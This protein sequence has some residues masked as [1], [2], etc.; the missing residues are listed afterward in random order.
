MTISEDAQRQSAD[1]AG[2]GG[3]DIKELLGILRRRKKVI[4]STVLL[5]TSLAVLAGLQLTPKYTAT[6]MVMI[7]PRK[8]T[9]VDVEAVIQG[10][11]TDASTVESQIRLISSRF[12][13]ERLATD[14]G[15]FDDP[16]FNAALR[17]PDR[18]VQLQVAGPLEVIVSWLPDSWLVATGLA[19][20]PIE[21]A[22]VDLPYLQHESTIEA[23][24]KGLKVA[25]E[26]RSYV[27][28]IA[29]TSENAKKAANV[30]NAAANRYVDMLREEKVGKTELATEWLAQRLDELRR[31]VEVAEGAAEEYRAKNNINDVNG[32][33]LNEQRLFDVNQRLSALR[34]DYAAA[35]AKV[36]QIRAMRISGFD[37]TEAVPEVLA[38]AT[39]INL[40]ER[41]T[42]LL[43]EESDMRSTYGAKHPRI[44]SI[45]QEKS[46]LQRKIQAE[47]SRILK[48]IEND[49]E[50][51]A[52]RIN[53]LER[54]IAAVSGGTSIDREVAVK[55]RELERDADASRNIYNS[56]LE[57]YKETADQQRLIEADAKVVSTAAPPTTPSTPGPKL[58]GAVGFTASLMLGTLLA[59]LME[60]FDS[61][62]R[63][64]RQVE[65]T[66]GLPAL[67]LVP[68]LERLR[69]NQKPHQ[70][71]LAKPLSAYAESVR[72]IYTSLQLSNVDD[73]PRV[74]LVTSSLP[75]EGKT[76]LALSLATFAA[77]SGQR[78]LL[79]DVDLRHPNVHRDLAMPP[80]HG[81]VEYMAGE[82]ELDEVLVRNEEAGIWYLPIKRQTANPTDLLGS[83]KMKHLLSQLRERFDFVVLDS[84][85]LLGVTDTKVVSRF[86][87]KV[88]FVMQWDQTSR[89]TSINALGHM[90]EAKGHVAG[91][92]LTQV[93]VRK[94]AQYGYGD[95]GQYYGKYQKY[96]VN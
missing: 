89:E 67:G 49:T 52:S 82:R 71:L 81:L 18:D 57:R 6:A 72:A 20:E 25:P 61:G 51:T 23:F 60:R 85:P 40:R 32:M 41:E 4:L 15:I 35:Q 17:N 43:K 50:V 70:Y 96:Y 8:S 46:T 69:R 62:L 68:R 29:F 66:L 83:Q 93:D 2:E 90:R 19:A 84:A 76:T 56:F 5:L 39:I 94:H 80:E 55:L 86:A 75:Q 24:A 1:P 34:A 27:I 53:A 78:V 10:L 31:E 26:G 30:V 38:S 9:V 13:L 28:R 58:F 64:A 91:V 36:S 73:P 33:T 44:V 37:A 21:A 45:Q 47:V 59:L 22:E 77:S 95:V 16:E 79:M 92:V 48:T 42:Q 11:G 3:L 87:D 63:S 65:Q 12:Q 7:D 74:V 14:L 54:E 88:L